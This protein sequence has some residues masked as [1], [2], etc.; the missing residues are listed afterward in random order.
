[1]ATV[2]KLMDRLMRKKEPVS[3]HEEEE[4]MVAALT[5]AIHGTKLS[6]YNDHHESPPPTQEQD[7]NQWKSQDTWADENHNNPFNVSGP[8]YAE[9]SSSYPVV[10]PTQE[11]DFNQ[12]KSQDTWADENHNNPFNVS[13]P[14]YAEG[15]SSYPVVQPT[16]EQVITK[17]KK[18][19][20]R[21][22]RQRP[23]G[24]WAAEIRDPRM[25]KKVWL[26]TFETAEAAAVAYD[27]AAIRF[28]G[29]KAKLNFPE[30]VQSGSVPIGSVQGYAPPYQGNNESWNTV[31]YGTGNFA[32]QE[33]DAGHFSYPPPT[34]E[35]QLNQRQDSTNNYLGFDGSS[36]NTIEDW[37][38]YDVNNTGPNSFGDPNSSF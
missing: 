11:Q 37:S 31:E 22:V 28:K 5:E 26:G 32:T 16:Q 34:H 35:P 4:V 9:G 6:H 25:K 33:N 13:G 30:R 1:M 23:W 2:K 7:F 38:N 14:I 18:R 21:G 36:G 24:K 3:A 29:S 17:E 20:Y 10:Q 8:I 15:S 19:H 27:E 12:W